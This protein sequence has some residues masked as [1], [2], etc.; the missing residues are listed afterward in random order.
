[1]HQEG[2]ENYV[3]CAHQNDGHSSCKSAGISCSVLCACKGCN[4]PNGKRP[5][6]AGK[7]KRE[8]HSWQTI[9][10]SNKKFAASKGEEL[11]QGVW[12]DFENMVFS[13]SLRYIEYNQMECNASSLVPVYNSVVQYT[14]APYCSVDFPQEAILRNKSES[15][16]ENKLRHFQREKDLFEQLSK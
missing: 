2:K 4:N 8:P 9:S 16:L 10:I 12:S 13:N 14:N 5:I 15:Q 6:R 3:A 7:R 1:M 11:A